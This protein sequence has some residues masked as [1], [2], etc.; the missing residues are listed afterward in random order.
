MGRSLLP[1]PE[2][3]RLRKRSRTTVWRA[4]PCGRSCRNSRRSLCV[5]Q[6]RPAIACARS[7]RELFGPRFRKTMMLLASCPVRR[8]KDASTA[9]LMTWA[10]A[11]SAALMARSRT[12]LQICSVLRRS[13]SNPLISIPAT[14]VLHRLTDSRSRK[15]TTKLAMAFTPMTRQPSSTSKVPVWTG[16]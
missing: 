16:D 1:W 3:R 7:L 14:S 12:S 2:P 4:A 11:S 9:C 5:S 6:D 15:S 13:S 8:G 10:A